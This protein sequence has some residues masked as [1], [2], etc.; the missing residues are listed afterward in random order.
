M[1]SLSRR[2]F[3][4]WSG[5]ALAGWGLSASPA[6][7]VWTADGD[8]FPIPPVDLRKI[9]P[10]FRRTIVPYA[11]AEWPGTIIVDTASRHL[12]LILEGGQA[13]R[14]GVGVGRAGFE[15]S[16][17]ADVGYKVMWPRW[18]PPADMVQRDAEA[19]KWKDG[20][21][22]GPQNPLGARA[23]YLYQ[24]G[25]D[26]LYR[27]HGTN[28]PQSIGKAMSSGC[29]RMLNQDVV[30]L[31]RRAPIGSRVIVLGAGV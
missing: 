5:A 8:P 7:A 26:T 23:L 10:Q 14:Y 27:L 2:H 15:W 24:N 4:A 31:Y 18:I 9:P 13:I 3:L 6:A 22:G 19:A 12:Y 11:E 16:G 20:M 25:R 29:I 17:V 30:E 1:T 21:P 28:A